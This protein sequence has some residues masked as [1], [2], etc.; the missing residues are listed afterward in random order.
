MHKFSDKLR[1]VLAEDILAPDTPA[2]DNPITAV[3]STLERLQKAREEVA[4]LERELLCNV[5][6]VN[7]QLAVLIRNR[8]PGLNVALGNGECSVG[9]RS[10][11]LRLKPDFSKRTWAVDGPDPAFARRFTRRHNTATVIGDGVDELA[12]ALSDYFATHYKTLGDR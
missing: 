5:E 4:G 12:N 9:Y 7:G 10:K 2:P 11:Q 3:R 8:N 1:S 6:K